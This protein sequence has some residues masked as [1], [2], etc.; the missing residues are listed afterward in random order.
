VHSGRFDDGAECPIKVDTQPL[1]ETPEDL[2]SLVPLKSAISPELVLE[3]PLACHD[4][5]TRRAWYQIPTSVQQK[6]FGTGGREVTWYVA[7]IQ[8]PLL[9][10]VA[11]V[12]Q[13]VTRRTTTTPFGRAAGGVEEGAGRRE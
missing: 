2:M 5:G 1:C 11:T 12:C 10:R 8:K 9:A 6:V 4:V 3:D 13:F 7:G